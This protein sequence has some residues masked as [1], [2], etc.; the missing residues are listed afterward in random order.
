M[1]NTTDF[2][3]ICHKDDIPKKGSRRI[4]TVI[5]EIALFHTSDGSI[6][7]LKN[8]CPHKKGP[9]SEGIV[10]GHSVTCP[11]HNWII[12]FETGEA[13]GSDSGCTPTLAVKLD[14]E[15]GVY[16][17]MPEASEMDAVA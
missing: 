15:G 3:L 13:Q 14:K 4:Q 12:N 17:A 2:A 10:H 9:L 8:E 6:F 7:A 11:L 16:L 5:G 1:T